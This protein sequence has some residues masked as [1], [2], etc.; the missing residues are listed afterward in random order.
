V[1]V[2]VAGLGAVVV[3]VDDEAAAAARGCSEGI[4]SATMLV[5][6]LPVLRTKTWTS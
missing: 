3:E 5:S 6:T 2:P 4:G 1:V